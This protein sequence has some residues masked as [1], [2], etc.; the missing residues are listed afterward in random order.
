[1]SNKIFID[2]SIFIRFLTQDDQ[3]KYADCKKI[4]EL[5]QVGKLRPYISQVVIL[6]IIFVLTRVYS[7]SK[8]RVLEAVDEIFRLRNITVIEITDSKKALQL[9]SKNKIEYQDCLIATQQPPHTTLLTYDKEFE[10]IF[11]LKI[12]TPAEMLTNSS[13]DIMRL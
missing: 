13:M 4:F 12:Q 6:E 3:Q 8:E 1:M 11:D 7:F 10:Q 9:Y 2:T 5:I